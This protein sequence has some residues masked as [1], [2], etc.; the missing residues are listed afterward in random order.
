MRFLMAG[1]GTG[2]HVIP[3]IAVARELRERGHEVWFVGTE[4]GAEGRLVPAAG[5]TLERIRIGGLQGMGVAKKVSSLLQLLNTTIHQHGAFGKRKPDAVFSM[6]GYVAGPPVI[7]ALLRKIPVVVMEPNAMPGLTN[8]WMG[9][10]VARALVSFPETGKWFPEGR[11]ELT[12][13]PVREE[14]FHLPPRPGGAF[15]VLI[16]GGSQGSRTLNNAARAAW[17]LLKKLPQPVRLLHQTGP[18]SADALQAEFAATGIAG[19]VSAFIDNMPAA[20]AQSDLVICRSGAGAVSELAAAGKPSI[21]IP[22]PFAADDHQLRNAEAME[23]AGAARLY[24]DQHWTAERM[25]ETISQLMSQPD[26]LRVMAEN[27]RALAKPGA[28]HRAAD[29]LEQIAR[30]AIDTFENSRNNTV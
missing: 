14:F 12:G 4:R 23:K 1:G 11:T 24:R 20:F 18:A 29:I 2:G 9:K 30:K 19:E 3:A 26:E 5:F 10:R 7:A 16:T 17:P 21:L 8:R 28:A 15:T 27:A 22:F 13:L 25:V 6:G